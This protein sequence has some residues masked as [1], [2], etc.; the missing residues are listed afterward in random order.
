MK[1]KITRFFWL[2]SGA[3]CSILE[4]CGTE[5]TKYV[6][7]GVAV[8][9]VSVS[10]GFS[11]GY[12]FYTVSS[13][14]VLS[15]VF[16][17][18]WGS[19]IFNIDRLIIQ[20]IKK[21]TSKDSK[22]KWR[23]GIL[24]FFSA[25]PR[26]FFAILIAFTV[27]VPLELRI[28][29]KEIDVQLDKEYRRQAEDYV[30]SKYNDKVTFWTNEVNRLE[31][32]ISY[33]LESKKKAEELS[34]IE[35]SGGEATNT[36]GKKI[37]TGR[38]GQGI[39]YEQAFSEFKK[40]EKEH[41]KIKRA[42]QAEINEIRGSLKKFNEVTKAEEIEKKKIEF[43]NSTGF[44]AR[45]EAIENLGKTNKS[46][47][48]ASILIRM[49]IA[50]LE[51]VPILTKLSFSRGEYDEKIEAIEAKTIILEAH[52]IKSYEKTLAHDMWMLE[53][54][55]K[56]AQNISLGYVKKAVDELSELLTTQFSLHLRK[57]Y[58]S[59]KRRPASKSGIPPKNT[60]KKASNSKGVNGKRPSKK[61]TTRQKGGAVLFSLGT[62][63]TIST[64][65]FGNLTIAAD[66]IKGVS[67]AIE[68]VMKIKKP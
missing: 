11:G 46:I 64:F 66:I 59:S 7:I 67:L 36:S 52:K 50:C 30:T 23:N 6:G 18:F 4:E 48:S 25:L 10:A 8:F 27:S 60:G 19:A 28:F 45:Y 12:A 38:Y 32:E 47:A 37:T 35:A 61:L 13:S 54:A 55:I 40:R 68:A 16:G 65:V 34:R 31:T 29:D 20:S 63:L 62:V 17:L 51:I 24:L 1:E 44:L 22:E 53:Q 42:N 57:N 49:L 15:I 43:N 2:C 14:Y 21:K 56:V 58:V 33:A 39:N 3:T 41:D 5:S 26:I 9:L